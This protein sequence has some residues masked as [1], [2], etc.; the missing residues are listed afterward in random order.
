MCSAISVSVKLRIC[1]SEYRV[2]ASVIVKME[3]AT[4]HVLF[5]TFLLVI[6]V[7]WALHM[8]RFLVETNANF[9]GTL[10]EMTIICRPEFSPGN[11]LPY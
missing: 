2:K 10:A 5:F 3:H 6:A 4:H 7:Q 9:G 8:K 11:V 1:F